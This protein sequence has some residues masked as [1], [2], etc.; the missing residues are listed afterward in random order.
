MRLPVI[1]VAV[2]RVFKPKVIVSTVSVLEWL[3]G[4][5]SLPVSTIGRHLCLLV[6]IFYYQQQ[7]FLRQL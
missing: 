2:S 6:E 5:V 7:L 1:S 4:L 3:I